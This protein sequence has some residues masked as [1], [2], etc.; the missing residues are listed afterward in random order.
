MRVNSFS[1]AVLARLAVRLLFWFSRRLG[2]SIIG[3]PLC[4]S[5]PLWFCSWSYPRLS[6]A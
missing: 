5:C 3:L 4:P 2:G 6:A 1:V